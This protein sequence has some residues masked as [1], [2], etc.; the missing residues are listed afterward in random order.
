MND[1]SRSIRPAGPDGL[2]RVPPFLLGATLLF[3]GWQTGSLWLGALTALLLESPRVMSTR[4]AFAQTDLDRIWN[5]CVLLVFASLVV[6]FASNDG[7]STITSLMESQTLSARS[8]ALS[9]T[10]RPAFMVFEW[11]PLTLLPMVLAQLFGERPLLD[12][13]TF[14]WRLRRLRAAR[15]PALPHP[16]VNVI[17]PY[18]AV[19]LIA[20]SAV[21]E[22]S[23]YFPFGLS[24]LVAWALW[25][26]RKRQGSAAAFAIS[27]VVAFLLGFATQTGLRQMQRMMQRLDAALVSRF[28]GS[29]ST[30][31]KETRTLIGS[32]GKL[33]LSG[34]IVMRLE[35]DGQLPPLRLRQTSYNLFRSPIWAVPKHEYDFHQVTAETNI[36]TTVLLPRKVATRA[37]T[38]SAYFS[39]EE[40]LLILPHGVVRVDELNADLE[41]N[42]LG[43][44]RIRPPVPGFARF[45]V[46][47]QDER[48]IDSAPGWEDSD[49][50]QAEKTVL[51]QIAAQL[52]LAGKTADQK[53]HAVSRFFAQNFSYST[54]L[55][56]EQRPASNQTALARFLLQTR[57][58][59]CEYFATATTLLL[60]Q[61]GI[62]ARYTVGFAVQERKGDRWI[63]RDRHAH[64]WC[65]AYLHGAWT[66]LDTTPGDWFGVEDS[67]ANWWESVTDRFSDIWYHFSKWRWSNGDWKQYLIWALVPLFGLTAW[68][69][70]SQKQWRRAGAR[71][72]SGRGSIVRPGLD[73]EFYLIE[74]ALSRLALERHAGETLSTWL[75]RVEQSGMTRAREAA[76]LLAV[77]YRLRFDPRGLTP[78]ERSEL[79]T[80]V[81]AWIRNAE[82]GVRSA[83]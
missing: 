32:I 64:A 58:G 4:W 19:C 59:H 46:S 10:A 73:S 8:Q 38:L 71:S 76:D 65:L 13:S 44:V 57:T 20:A 15:V 21:N 6:A 75:G 45:S 67:R 3:W 52:D 17:W 54:W 69:L 47:Y 56:P 36:T 16:G 53:V 82:C 81:T 29:G 55:G 31:E 23:I 43:V 25:T 40:K 74:R 51:Q 22:R 26:Q 66:E 28:G 80:A 34:N 41:T 27:L 79:R 49:V 61:A 50:P 60:R 78:T 7:V 14:R 24:I 12:V 37:A 11:M 35:T 63:I 77:H 33:K 2:S 30:D 5:L 62:P 1:T 39:Q 18:F 83:Q 70:L 9:K 42:G 68:R 72:G 48:S